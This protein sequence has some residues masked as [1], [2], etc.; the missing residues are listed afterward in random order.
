M[1]S[2]VNLLDYLQKGFARTNTDYI[3]FLA[4]IPNKLLNESFVTAS[5]IFL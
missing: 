1:S 3:H 2:K 4:G 5:K